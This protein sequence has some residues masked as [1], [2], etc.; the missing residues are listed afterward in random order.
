LGTIYLD[1]NATTPIDKRVTS[2]MLPF[3]TE[4]FGN[5]SSSHIFGIIAKQAVQKARSQLAALLG[6]SD[7]EIIFTSG[8]T[9]S[10]NYALKGIASLSLKKGNHIITSAI[11]HPAVI[12][13]CEY[14]KQQGFV[15][16]YLNV[17]SFGM[18]SIDDVRKAIRPETI[19][20]SIMLANNETGTI[21]PIAELAELAHSFR[22]PFHTDAAQAVGKIPLKI[23]D[24]NVDMI[25]VAGH[26]FYAPKGVGALYIKKGISLAKFLH[27]GNQEA[28]RRAGT[29]NVASIVGLGAAAQIASQQLQKDIA[30]SLS[31][32]ERLQKGIYKMFP[33]ARLNGHPTDRL[34]NTLNISFHDVSPDK[35][36]ELFSEI[37]ASSGAACHSDTV[38]ISPVLKAMKVPFEYARSTIR[39]SC[40]RFTTANEIDSALQKIENIL[41]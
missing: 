33:M 21:Q 12:N 8:G 27:G 35:I 13:V 1:Y 36:L 17:D 40:G 3:L 34:P 29:E 20:I 7:D 16:S 22:I 25:S 11:E 37:A 9:E 2:A 41:K 30:N 18:V 24:L 4:H 28:D 23:N 5:P 32:R 10:N 39:F 19:L 15:I 14:L 38:Q 6:C 31:C 26:K